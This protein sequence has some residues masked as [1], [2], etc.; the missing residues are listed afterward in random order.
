MIKVDPKKII[1]TKPR[2]IKSG[3]DFPIGEVLVLLLIIILL[4]FFL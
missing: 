3:S 2:M 4:T 1:Y